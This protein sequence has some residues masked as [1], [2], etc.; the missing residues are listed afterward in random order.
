MIAVIF[1]V[2]PADEVA[3][4]AYLEIA[5]RLRPLLDGIDGFLSIERYQSLTDPGNILSLSFWR[6]ESSVAAWRNLEEHRAAQSAGRNGIF[7]DYRLRIAHV[8][9]DYGLNERS[10]APTDSRAANG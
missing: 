6:D 4:S 5:A 2:V 7:R 1:E 3:R 9:R 10:Q 8:I